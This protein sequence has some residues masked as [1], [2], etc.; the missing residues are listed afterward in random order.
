MVKFYC[1]EESGEIYG[2]AHGL[3]CKALEEAK[4]GEFRNDIAG[5]GSD[6]YCFFERYNCPRFTQKDVNGNV[7]LDYGNY[8]K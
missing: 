1:N 4:L 5:A 2:D 7:T 8:V 6:T 3:V